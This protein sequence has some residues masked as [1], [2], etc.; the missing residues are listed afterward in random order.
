MVVL[1]STISFQGRKSKYNTNNSTKVVKIANQFFFACFS[2]ILRSTAMV[3]ACNPRAK[4]YN[5][6]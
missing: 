5:D 2:I 1:K 6:F 3:D 4:R